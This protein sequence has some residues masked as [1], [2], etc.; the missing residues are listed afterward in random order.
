MDVVVQLRK[1][2]A[3]GN[4]L[5]YVN[6]PVPVP[7]SEVPQTNVAVTT[8]PQGALRASHACTYDKARSTDYK[9]FYKHD[10]SVPVKPG[11]VVRLE[12]P[13]WPWGA[14]FAAGEHLVL[15]ISGHNMRLPETRMIEE[16][17]V[18]QRN[19]GRHTLYSGGEYESYL[20]IPIINA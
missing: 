19:I 18:E 20:S 16:K 13:I 14:T 12:I 5:S 2:D 3:R 17:K 6:Y 9:P 15:R 11:T 1:A 8:G 10:K 7:K 4:I